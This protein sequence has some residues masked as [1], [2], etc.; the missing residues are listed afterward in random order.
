MIE[1]FDG[2]QFVVEK[3]DYLRKNFD[4]NLTA[5][6]VDRG[7]GPGCGSCGLR[8]RKHD[9]PCPQVPNQGRSVSI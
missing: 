6:D 5:V 1:T 7:A 4:F 9:C 3:I 2:D 8:W